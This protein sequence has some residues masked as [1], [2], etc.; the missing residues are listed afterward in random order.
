MS[1]RIEDYALIGDNHGAAL[2]GR[3]GSIDWLCLPRFDSGASFAALLGDP[4]NG[5]WLICPAAPPLRVER[6]YRDGTLILETRFVCEAGEVTLTDCML[7]E[8]PRPRLVRMARCGRGS[9]AMR[10]EYVVR[11]DYGSIVPWVRQTNEGLLAIAGPDALLLAG[12]VELRPDGWRHVADF[13]LG[14]G[15]RATFELSYFPS[16]EPPPKATPWPRRRGAGGPG[17]SRAATKD[18]TAPSSTGRCWR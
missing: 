10:L 17:P 5:R 11:F 8:S 6:S 14:K 3:D 9:V 7:L 16:H 4:A 1:L 15:E 18:R 2:V 12:D 13:T